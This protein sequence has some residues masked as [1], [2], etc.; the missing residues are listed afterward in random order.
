MS[1]A[2]ND[3]QHSSL[4]SPRLNLASS[5]ISSENVTTEPHCLNVIFLQQDER[6][7]ED[8][9][10]SQSQSG[11]TSESEQQTDDQDQDSDEPPAKR[12]RGKTLTKK[13]PISTKD[14][15]NESSEDEPLGQ[16]K[17][18]MA[19]ARVCIVLSYILC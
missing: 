4:T 10:Q 8:E 7:K 18:K 17:R 13:S 1:F 5:Y 3:L 11:V 2:R 9:A 16:T 14:V 19:K 15:A 6:D 12:K